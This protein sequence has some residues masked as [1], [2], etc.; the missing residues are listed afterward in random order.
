M[1]GRLQ[2]GKISNKNNSKYCQ[3]GKLLFIF[4][5]RR[6]V[7]VDESV[8]GKILSHFSGSKILHIGSGD[9]KDVNNMKRGKLN[10]VNLFLTL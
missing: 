2:I 3:V 7:Y 1:N 8:E 10:F 4:A 9:Q 5:F 6:K